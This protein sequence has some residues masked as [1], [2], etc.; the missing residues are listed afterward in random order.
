VGDFE[1][2]VL[3]LV[4]EGKLSADEG[5]E[6]LRSHERG[7]LRD[8]RTVVEDSLSGVGRVVR[9][10]TEPDVQELLH[11]ELQESEEP[12]ELRVDGDF[13]LALMPGEEGVCRAVWSVG[14]PF[15]GEVPPPPDVRLEGRTLRVE[16]RAR[17]GFGI[18]I[19][20]VGY[21]LDVYLP[22]GTRLGGTVAQ[23]LGRVR[24][25]D[26]PVETLRLDTQNG[27]VQVDAPSIRDLQVASRNGS[28]EVSAKEAGKVRVEAY[29]GRVALRGALRDVDAMTRNGRIEAELKPVQGGRCRLQTLN[30]A[31]E[32]E[33]ARGISC[34]LAAETVHGPISVDMPDLAV[35]ED[36]RD[37]SRRRLRGRTSGSE[38]DVEAELSTTNGAVRVVQ[39]QR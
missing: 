29:N 22:A 17:Y 28:I 35:E 12:L 37:F 9:E 11:A 7:T 31:V 5:E 27:R 14:R 1:R 13:G 21:T 19:P 38:G 15:F 25:D 33:L 2:R 18:G 39:R 34:K 23:R 26:L 20:F 16:G 3:R 4:A 32:L 6:L 8:L 10:H 30:G 24:I 36:V